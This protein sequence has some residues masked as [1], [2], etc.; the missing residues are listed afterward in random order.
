MISL[1]KIKNYFSSKPSELEEFCNHEK[2]YML[3][4]SSSEEKQPDMAERMK[5]LA[6]L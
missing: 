6:G 4:K 1:S 3:R 5:Q 2:Y